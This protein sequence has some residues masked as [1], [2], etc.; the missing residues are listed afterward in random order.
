MPTDRDDDYDDRAVEKVLADKPQWFT[1][2]SP[3][4][5]TPAFIVPYGESGQVGIMA[6]PAASCTVW[7]RRT[8][9]RL[10]LPGT[11]VVAVGDAEASSSPFA[12]GESDA[13]QILCLA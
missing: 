9:A 4:G 6:S 11:C 3:Y 12:G 2:Y 7:G 5:L 8:L 10:R 1:S 13:C